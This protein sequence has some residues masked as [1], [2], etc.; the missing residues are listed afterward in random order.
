MLTILTQLAGLTLGVYIWEQGDKAR[1]AVIFSAISLVYNVDELVRQVPY[2]INNGIDAWVAAKRIQRYLDQPDM[3]P[4]LTPGENISFE[5]ATVCW[6]GVRVEKVMESLDGT[7]SGESQK[8]RST[9]RNISV[10]FPKGKLS[11]VT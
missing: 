9:L 3:A 6:P 11:I 8:A 1:A 5:D 2:V 7:G 4:V 10:S